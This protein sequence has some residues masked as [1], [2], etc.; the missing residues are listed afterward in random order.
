MISE[1]DPYFF[2]FLSPAD[3]QM[4]QEYVTDLTDVQFRFSTALHVT[5]FPKTRNILME[6]ALGQVIGHVLQSSL[7]DMYVFIDETCLKDALELVS[8]GIEFGIE[9]EACPPWL[10]SPVSF[11]NNYFHYFTGA[12][13]PPKGASHTMYFY[14]GLLY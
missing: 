7:L 12:S 3:K 14:N 1:Y 4:A 6:P 10:E 11:R 5:T 13:G 2:E 9:S 8:L